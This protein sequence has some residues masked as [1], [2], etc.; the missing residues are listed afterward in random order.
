MRQAAVVLCLHMLL[1]TPGFA[2]DAL[3]K[4][5]SAHGVAPAPKGRSPATIDHGKPERYAKIP[6]SAGD[7][8]RIRKLAGDLE[9]KDPETTLRRIAAFIAYRVPDVP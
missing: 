8:K 9:A 7:A 4:K 2:D 5:R 6:K 1:A 3:A